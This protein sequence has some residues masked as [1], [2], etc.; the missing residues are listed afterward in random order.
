MTTTYLELSAVLSMLPAIIEV[1][2]ERMDYPLI[3]EG[4]LTKEWSYW[5]A[6]KAGDLYGNGYMVQFDCGLQFDGD[7]IVLTPHQD[8]KKVIEDKLEFYN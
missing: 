8:M 7:D 3:I 2:H 5:I 1:P 4:D 6:Y